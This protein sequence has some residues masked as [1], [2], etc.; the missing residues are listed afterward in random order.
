MN[1]NTIGSTATYR[2]TRAD[3]LILL[4]GATSKPY[5]DVVGDPT[6]GIGFNLKYNLASVLTAM[7]G[8]SHYSATLLDRLQTVVDADYSSGQTALLQKRLDAVMK[9]WHDSRDSAVPVSFVFA[10][11]SQISAALTAIAP[12]YDGYVDRWLSGIPNSTERA[13][14]F[15]LAY[16]NPSLLGPDLKAAI[17]AGD[18]AEAWYEIRY[19]SNG[20]KIAGIANRRYVEAERFQLFDTDGKASTAQA[21]DAGVMYA[22]H[23]DKILS[24]EALWSPTNAAEIKGESGIETILDEM[25]PAMT[26]L[27]AT[28]KIGSGLALE[29]LQVADG[30]LTTLKGDGTSH[31]S[32]ANDADLLVGSA[33]A[34]RL[35]GGNGTDALIGNGGN[36]RLYGGNGNDWLQGGA[37]ADRLFGGAGR[38]VFDF[39]ALSDSRPSQADVIS[40][41]V[42]GQDRI[43]LSHIDGTGQAAGY[44]F[45]FLATEG[46]AFT[47][48]AGELKWSQT[49]TGSNA[50]TIIEGDVNGDAAADLKIILIGHHDLTASDFLL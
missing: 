46:A 37:G 38:D 9:T 18:R 35:E 45:S 7:V 23:R 39:N 8:K 4:E 20:S 1:W 22:T 5:L 15:S 10:N 12:T 48:H 44:A 31:D 32:A 50:R 14:L 33:S 16:N 13:V 36:D 24:Y 47:R 21:L 30:T 11:S 49:G 42:S 41:F 28:Y 17:L 43:D 3:L 40:G 25:A 2:T 29:E 6:I 26:R 27:K 19:N 34:N